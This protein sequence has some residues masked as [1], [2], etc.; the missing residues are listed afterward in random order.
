MSV[1]GSEVG[2]R[3]RAGGGSSFGLGT[4]ASADPLRREFRGD[5]FLLEKWR[6]GFGPSADV[7][8]ATFDSPKI[9][10]ADL[11]KNTI[12]IVPLRNT[13]TTTIKKWN[14]NLFDVFFDWEFSQIFLEFSC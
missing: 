11:S 3:R 14:E 8:S 1:S 9:P 7:P 5:F 4:F 2:F 6:L 10:T 13:T 12:K